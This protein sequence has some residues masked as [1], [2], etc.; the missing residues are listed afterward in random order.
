MLRPLHL[1][2]I[3]EAKFM[4]GSGTFEIR[5][6]HAFYGES[7]ILREHPSLLFQ[8]AANQPDI[9]APTQMAKV[10]LEAGDSMY[11]ES[12]TPHRGRALDGDAQALVV[13]IEPPSEE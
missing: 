4:M 2:I 5:D 13:I 11:F 1:Q 12:N 6:L 3:V 10:R 8:Q 9:T 7:H